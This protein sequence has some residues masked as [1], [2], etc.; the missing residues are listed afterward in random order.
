MKLFFIDLWVKQFC[1]YTGAEQLSKWMEAGRNQISQCWGG[2]GKNYL[3]GNG[4]ELEI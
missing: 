1:M 2:G 3:Y 4:T